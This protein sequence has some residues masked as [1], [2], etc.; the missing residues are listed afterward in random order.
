MVRDQCHGDYWTLVII[1]ILCLIIGPFK[2]S[3]HAV[4]VNHERYRQTIVDFYEILNRRSGLEVENRRLM[5]DR[6]LPHTANAMMSAL[7]ESFADRL[8][9][10][11][12]N[13]AWTSRSPT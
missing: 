12:A 7:R 1:I 13:F 10:K 4:P 9:S 5:Q 11:K 8:I 6:A 2:E 3:G